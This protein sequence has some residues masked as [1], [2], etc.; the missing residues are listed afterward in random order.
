MIYLDK[1]IA[2]MVYNLQHTP[3]YDEVLDTIALDTAYKIHVLLVLPKLPNMDM[4]YDVDNL[5]DMIN[6]L[7]E[8]NSTRRPIYVHLPLGFKLGNKLKTFIN[9]G[10]TFIVDNNTKKYR[11]G[12]IYLMK[13]KNGYY[14]RVSKNVYE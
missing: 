14:Y 13:R 12:N 9:K 5:Y 8:T 10:V 6:I 7:V 2:V 11:F 3:S 4:K 1:N